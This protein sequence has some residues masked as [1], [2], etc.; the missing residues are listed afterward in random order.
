[1]E[2]VDGKDKAGWVMENGLYHV[3][4]LALMDAANDVLRSCE[5]SIKIPIILIAGAA[6]STDTPSNVLT[7]SAL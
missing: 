4:L 3:Q 2:V 7:S 1:M 5:W 6:T